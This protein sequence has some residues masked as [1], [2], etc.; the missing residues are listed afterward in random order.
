MWEKSV[1]SHK[2]IQKEEKFEN[3]FENIILSEQPSDLLV[4]KGTLAC[5]A[6][7]ADIFE[8]PPQE[9]KFLK[10]FH[11]IFPKE[12][13][14]ELSPFRGIEH[15]IDLVIGASISNRPTYGTNH[16]GT[17]EIESQ[18]QE[19][20][21]K[22]WIRKSLSPCAV[23][24]F[25]VPKKDGKWRMCYDCRAIS[26]VTIKYRHP[27]LKLDNMLDELHESTIF[28]KIDLKSGYHK[29]RIKEGDEL[30]TT[31]KT[32]FGLYEWL[33]KPFGFT[34]APRTFMRL[35]HHVLRN[36]IGKYVVVYFD[37]ML[38]YHQQ[39]KVELSIGIYKDKILCDVMPKETCHA[40]L[41]R[42]L[43]IAKNSMLKTP[44]PGVTP[45]SL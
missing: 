6:T 35:M 40:L 19:L 11:D 23:P 30:K 16:D 21:E 10:E 38:R 15:Q 28:F 27:I 12:N 2:V 42:P 8:L 24:I 37:Y 18:F 32:K 34:N 3:K 1:P 45:F 17:K 7:L 5:T 14:I 41:R 4:C 39:V 36:C 26:N 25:L 43:Q 33:V 22:G 9:K 44:R 31:F 29:I 20:L 13:L